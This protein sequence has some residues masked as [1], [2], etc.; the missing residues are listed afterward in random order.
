[1]KFLLDMP[2]SMALLD[3]LEAHGHEGVH[4]HQIGKDRT[5]DT[6]LLEMARRESRVVI[7]ADLDFPR[8]LALSMAEGPGLILFRGANYSDRE[9]CDLLSGVLQ[10]VP[11]ELLGRSICVVDTKHIRVTTLPLDRRP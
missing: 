3:V 7:T 9:M 8:L 5:S 2:V 10:K 4:A 6:E 1:M 11:S